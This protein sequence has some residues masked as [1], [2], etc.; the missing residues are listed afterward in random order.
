MSK[1][2]NWLK[3]WRQRHFVVTNEADNFRINFFAAPGGKQTGFIDLCGYH[4]EKYSEEESAA[5]KTEFGLK[6][7]PAN[8]RRKVWLF[9]CT[10]EEERKAWLE[11]LEIVCGNAQPPISKDPVTRDAFMA[12][13]IET[14]VKYGYSS[15]AD[16]TGSETDTLSDLIISLLERDVLQEVY[17]GM[18]GFIANFVKKNV[19]ATVTATVNSAWTAAVAACDPTK[20]AV[21][22][23]V[24]PALTEYFKQEAEVK[25][26]IVAGISDTMSPFITKSSEAVF[27]PAADTIVE[28]ITSTFVSTIK[29]VHAALAALIEKEEFKKAES[30]EKLLLELN[31]A[32]ATWD[33]P[34]SSAKKTVDD[35]VKNKFTKIAHMAVKSF[36][37]T[38]LGRKIMEK[39]Y[40]LAS[41]A[42]Y[43]FTKKLAEPAEA[44]DALK[45]T[46]ERMVHDAQI[47]LKEVIVDI[48]NA[49]VAD[50]IAETIISPC[51]TAVAPIQDFINA[52]PG[53]LSDFFNLNC[54]IEDCVGDIVG[55][56][57]NS[58]V[59]PL[60][61]KGT[62][63][64]A[65]VK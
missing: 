20:Q 28:E 45:D 50:P 10:N 21:E 49:L 61:V 34:L 59:D 46:K 65:D 25:G 43:T 31:N 40:Q 4:P 26:K 9:K 62:A 1:Q 14:R 27:R 19:N 8:E 47:Y 29:D 17:T 48:L 3:S 55:N 56:A 63:K 44:K 35:A 30:Q 41:Y 53:G 23:A 57:I 18:I 39:N 33:G 64:I 15:Y 51:H 36:S 60:L 24:K 2:S 5:Y 54:L 37:L 6:L 16:V 58:V 38:R 7:V 42:V 12:A 32:I 52:I 22:A 11:M 13:Y